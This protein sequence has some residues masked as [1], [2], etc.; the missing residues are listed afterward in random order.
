MLFQLL[1]Y[2]YNDSIGA[3]QRQKVSFALLTCKAFSF[4]YGSVTFP[5]V[6]DA[7][8]SIA[9]RKLLLLSCDVICVG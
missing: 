5:I 3:I 9:L 6:V 4:R 1:L 8:C 2:G 7:S